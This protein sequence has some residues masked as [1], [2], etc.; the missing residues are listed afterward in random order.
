MIENLL[1]LFFGKSDFNSLAVL[2]EFIGILR[3]TFEGPYG[4]VFAG[5]GVIDLFLT[6]EEK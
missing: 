2:I 3:P 4:K 6:A 1:A 5:L